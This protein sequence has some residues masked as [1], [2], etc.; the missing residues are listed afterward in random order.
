MDN[1]YHAPLNDDELGVPP[2]ETTALAPHLQ[3]APLMDARAVSALV[4]RAPAV[5]GAWS[6]G[7]MECGDNEA[8]CASLAANS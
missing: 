2:T 3:G 7:M 1:S 8:M 5:A 6:S 4:A